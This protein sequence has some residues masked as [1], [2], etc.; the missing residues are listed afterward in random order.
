VAFVAR[1]AP[2]A[3]ISCD[4]LAGGSVGASGAQSACMMGGLTAPE[5]GTSVAGMHPP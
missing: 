4:V 5:L 1:A 2:V 3:T